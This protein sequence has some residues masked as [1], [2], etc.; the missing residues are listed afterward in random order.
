MEVQAPPGNTIGYIK[1]NWHMFK[2]KFSI[3][4]MSNTKVLSIE[5]P[6]CAISCCG[7]VDFDVCIYLLLCPFATYMW[8]RSFLRYLN[9][10]YQGEQLLLVLIFALCFPDQKKI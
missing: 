5:G 8:L 9:I 1:Q 4:D 7:D 3:Y 6:L 10:Q 2:P